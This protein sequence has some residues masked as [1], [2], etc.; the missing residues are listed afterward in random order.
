MS[1]AAPGTRAAFHRG[2]PTLYRGRR[3]V[4]V[5]AAAIVRAARPRL[6]DAARW[7]GIVSIAAVNV[8]IAVLG[9]LGGVGV[10]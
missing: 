8:G 2:R 5:P 10:G 7:L 4:A 9:I 6:V 3:R 1:R